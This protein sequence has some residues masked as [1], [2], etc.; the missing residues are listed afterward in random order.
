MSA[1]PSLDDHWEAE[2]TRRA[3][4]ASDLRSLLDCA[5]CSPFTAEQREHI[6]AMIRLYLPEQ[7]EPETTT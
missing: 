3:V 1:N 7:G 4:I 2:W 6:E 5:T